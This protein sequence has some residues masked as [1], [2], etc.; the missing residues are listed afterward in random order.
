MNSSGFCTASYW[1][2]FRRFCNI[3]P[4]VFYFESMNWCCCLKWIVW[5]LFLRLSAL[6]KV[7]VLPVLAECLSWRARHTSRSKTSCSADLWIWWTPPACFWPPAWGRTWW[8]PHRSWP[9]ASS[10]ASYLQ[11]Q[12]TPLMFRCAASAWRTGTFRSLS[13]DKHQAQSETTELQ[14]LIKPD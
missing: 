13:S 1:G 10:C 6:W 3:S 9:R 12:T 11:V 8:N 7:T 14:I 5:C 4:L 2:K